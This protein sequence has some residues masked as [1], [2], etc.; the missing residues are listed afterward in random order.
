MSRTIGAELVDELMLQKF[1]DFLAANFAR[2]DEHTPYPD[3]VLQEYLEMGA[4]R[5]FVPEALG[6]DFKS[7]VGLMEFVE[8]TSF[9]SL[10]LGLSI[11]IA[12]SLFLRPVVLH[13]Q[14]ELRDPIVSE[15]LTKPALGG[16]M[17]TE[18]SG[19][20][21]VAAFQ[22]SYTVDAGAISLTGTKCWGGL[23]GKAGHWLVAARLK[24]GGKL[25]NRMAL[26]YVPLSS[27]GI[28][29][30]TYFNVLGLRPIPYGET[31]YSGT[32]LPESS[33]VALP[34]ESPTRAI[35]DTLFRSRLGLP[36]I[37]AGHCKRMAQE[38]T[39]RAGS[40]TVSGHPIADF[41][42][43]QLTLSHLRGMYEVTHSL[44]KFS[45]E[46]MDTHPE[47]TGDTTLANTAKIIC[48][49]TMSMASDAAL[50]LFASAAYKRNHIVGRGFVDSRPFRIFEGV[51]EVL[52]EQIYEMIVRR[53]GS[54]DPEMVAS[55]LAH[56]GLMP[57]GKIYKT[58]LELFAEPATTQRVRVALGRILA[59]IVCLGIVENATEKSDEQRRDA[60]LF[61]SRQIAASAASVPYLG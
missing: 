52:D 60:T 21:D 31:H 51:N 4:L 58:T 2:I 47:V 11:G 3:A 55:E 8:L 61:V 20:T 14:A 9:H 53:N 40:H 49:E 39:R 22:T 1:S 43:V 59:W 24:R 10:P 26:I 34:D 16:L 30:H 13:G 45:G 7:A 5:Q 18:P 27:N 50:Q 38:A 37:S 44:G 57:S 15:F 32:R 46:W 42:Q 35:Y 23:T 6:G 48:T 19:G 17:L 25:T 29:V 54:C 12:G 41:D 56:Y 36:S 28:K 33:I